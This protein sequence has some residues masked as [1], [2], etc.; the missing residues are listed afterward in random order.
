MAL[1]TV[2]PKTAR[3]LLAAAEAARPE[4]VE[5]LRRLVLLE[6]PTDRPETQAAVQALLGEALEEIGYEVEHVPGRETGGHLWAR[7]SDGGGAPPQIL[8][9]H[10]DTVWPVG[11]LGEMPLEVREDVLSGPGSYDMKGGLVQMLFALRLLRQLELR[12]AFPPVVFVD[13]DEETG[14]AESEPHLVELARGAARVLVFEPAAGPEGRIKTARKGVGRFTVFIRGRPAHAGLEPERGRSAILELSHVVRQLHALSDPERGISVNVGVVEGGIRPNVVAP[15]A[16][17]EV[18][19]RIEHGGD[20]P[21]LVSAIRELRPAIPGVEL[22]IEGGMT[23][24]PLERTPGNRAL[25]RLTRRAGAA[26]GLD[27]EEIA[28]GGGS[29][30]NKTSPLAPTIDGLGP[31]GDGAHAPHEHVRLDRMPER[32]ALA[33]LLLLSPAETSA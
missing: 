19:V 24:P 27:L 22:V 2:D 13:S 15:S 31:V 10:S 5:L 32:T 3:S 12:P 4:M 9:G 6:S 18:D 16:R 33:A 23:H 30:G 7:P 20:G 25:W 14:G 11:T 28:V 17:A 1:S 21:S 26:L 29:D 8:L